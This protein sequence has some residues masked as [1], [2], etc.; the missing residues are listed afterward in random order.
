MREDHE[1]RARFEGLVAEVHEP[2]MRYLRRR[3]TVHDADDVMGE[4]LLTL[5]RRLDV[6]PDEARLPW[7]YAVARRTLANHRRGERRRLQLVGKLEAHPGPRHVDPA[8]A[9]GHPEL[10]AALA[11]LDDHDRE[12]VTLWA[13][14]ELEPREIALVLG[15]TPNA[16]S[17]RL[18]RLKKKIARHMARQSDGG[19]G[20]MGSERLGEQ[21]A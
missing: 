20:H 18:T 15:T 8:G 6:V 16:V 21:R 4:V 19:A 14:E 12:L 3:A 11:A 5:W 13:W 7:C 1:R 10:A 9:G 2:V 17:L